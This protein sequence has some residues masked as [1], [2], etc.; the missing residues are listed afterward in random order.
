MNIFLTKQIVLL[1]TAILTGLTGCTVTNSQVTPTKTQYIVNNTESTVSDRTIEKN[2]ID[3]DTI[4]DT[5]N[6]TPKNPALKASSDA[7]L[8]PIPLDKELATEFLDIRG[9]GDSAMALTYQQPL[10][11]DRPLPEGGLANFGERLDAFDPTGKSYRGDLSLINWESAVGQYCNQFRGQ[12]SSSSYT[13]VSHPINIAEAYRRGFNLIGL[14]N[15]HSWDCP[16]GEK[17]VHGALVSAT[18]MESLTKQI[19]ANW[20][21][22]GVGNDLQKTTAQVKTM[23]VKG[24]P[25]KIAFASLYLGSACT[26]ITCVSDENKVLQSLRDADA[27]L[28]IISIHSWDEASQQH[29]V[30]TGTKFIRDYRGDIVFG[31]GPHEW[32]PVNI[33]QS[34]SGKKGVMFESLGNF[35]HPSLSAKRKDLIGRVLFDLETLQIRQIQAIPLKVD[36]SNASFQ[37]ALAATSIPTKNFTWQEIA[38][39]DW[40]G[41]ISNQ[42]QGVYF[43]ITSNNGFLK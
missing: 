40:Q 16:V 11:P 5:T 8:P 1:A 41:K 42:I 43:N 39:S 27:D 6:R 28:R 32:K 35:I 25:I 4:S 7:N 15:N 31:H 17:G 19:S 23:T 33:I 34:N 38:Q 26:N 24:K 20:L 12:P 37:G 3:K 14:A 22:H 30:A 9:V 29:L 10:K 21:W 18:Y 36:A 2:K 13:F